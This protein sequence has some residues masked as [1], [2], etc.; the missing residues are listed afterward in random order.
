MG[1]CL[2]FGKPHCVAA[3]GRGAV[4]YTRSSQRAGQHPSLTQP[5]PRHPRR[6]RQP[7]SQA[8]RTVLSPASLSSPS[9]GEGG[10]L[11]CRD[12]WVWAGL[13][14]QRHS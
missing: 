3:A 8:H 2:Y 12:P 10:V 14:G 1:L 5:P 4:F 13:R 6:T 11:G 9:L 7:R